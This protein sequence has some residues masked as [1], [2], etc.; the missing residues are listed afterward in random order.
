M[1]YNKNEEF[2]K[3]ILEGMLHILQTDLGYTKLKT[4]NEVNNASSVHKGKAFLKYYLYNFFIKLNDVDDD[5]IEE[6][7]LDICTTD[8]KNDKG[9]DFILIDGSDVYVIQSK[10]GYSGREYIDSLIA[11]PDNVMSEYFYKTANN[12][13][14]SFISEIKKIQHPN[15]KLIY[16]TSERINDDDKNLY[17]DKNHLFN[18]IELIIKDFPELRQD[19][20]T[21]DSSGELP[22]ETVKFILGQEDV[23]VLNELGSEHPTILITQKGSKLKQLYLRNDCMERLFNLNIRSWLGRNAVNKAMEETIKNEPEHFFY[24]NNGIT[25]I[26]ESFDLSDDESYLTCNKLQIIN[27]AQTVTTIAK[28]QNDANLSKVKVLFRIISAGKYGKSNH[29]CEEIVTNN[30]NQTIIQ[31]SDFRSNDNIQIQIERKF[32]DC[33]LKYRLQY[34]FTT[35]LLYKRKRMQS[36][37][38]N[39]YVTMKDL[40]KC[41]Y[42]AFYEPHTLNESIKKMWD[43]SDSGLYNTVFGDN[44]QIL[45]DEQFY[46]LLG[47]YYIMEY[48]KLKIPKYKM[49]ENKEDIYSEKFKYHILWGIVKLLKK[50]YSDEEISNTILRRMIM[51]GAYIS[52]DE[53]EEKE[54]LFYSYFKKVV[55]II[56][57]EIKKIQDSKK[58]KDE[59][60]VIR[61]YQRDSKFTN[62]LDVEFESVEIDD[63]KELL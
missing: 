2:K 5:A 9:C 46:K 63:L 28:C 41:Y 11:F 35:D 50:K 15:F 10:Y 58:S 26:C 54:K 13:L 55:K 45:S 53:S 52:Q 43:N 20:K 32:K 14:K 34:P 59:P 8:G 51:R 17:L 62:I 18:N 29:L 56:D 37:R 30:N 31:V 40:G 12:K 16:L 4:A 44:E 19:K 6:G 7:L 38:G 60:F 1:G 33:K 24:Y 48:I 21:I 47:S 3:I 57:K 22:P 27:G 49:D 25:G 61:N 23:Q 36:V 42:S 39:K